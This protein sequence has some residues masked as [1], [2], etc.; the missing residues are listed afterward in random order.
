MIRRVLGTVLLLVAIALSLVFR[1][2]E[3]AV[4]L[5]TLFALGSQWE[6]T[7]IISR[8]SGHV[9]ARQ[10][11]LLTVFIMLGSWYLCPIYSGLCLALLSL[12]ILL[13]YGVVRFPPAR[14]TS[15]LAPSLFSI[16]Y[17]PF[18]LQF[19][20]MLLRSGGD[21]TAGLWL[22]AWVVTVGK[23]GDIGALL[24]GCGCGRHPFAMEYSPKKTWEGF[25]GGTLT[26]MGGGFFLTS[27][28]HRHTSFPIPLRWAMPLAALLAATGA[29]SD[30]LESAL[31]RQ[32]RIK[33]SG[34]LIPG[35]GGC[36]DFCDTFILT[37]PAAYALLHLLGFLPR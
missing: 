25:L 34:R 12:I 37:F 20:V 18:A 10:V 16:L 31:K 1:G 19:G 9:L 35:I 33:D 3:G 13:F 5:L 17:I 32:A 11:S 28:A 23:L 29:L 30:L 8:C 22:L 24:V 26:A 2:S 36:L 15:Y 21:G 7:R 27:L 14:L 6:L 4:C